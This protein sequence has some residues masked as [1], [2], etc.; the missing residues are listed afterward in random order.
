MQTLLCDKMF[1]LNF[2]MHF[3]YNYFTKLPVK[4]TVNHT[5][6]RCESKVKESLVGW[7]CGKRVQC[8]GWKGGGVLHYCT[9]FICYSTS[10]HTTSI[11]THIAYFL[12]YIFVGCLL[13]LFSPSLLFSVHI[14]LYAL[15]VSFSNHV[16]CSYL[17]RYLCVICLWL[18]LALFF[19][20]IISSPEFVQS[21]FFSCFFLAIRLFF[22]LHKCTLVMVYSVSC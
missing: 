11:Y 4:H 2:I 20:Y 10:T 8:V 19:Y 15:L 9:N 6:C 16:L 17:S 14:C 22:V 5:K 21:L 1:L 7:H 13:F 12:V 3:V 18:S